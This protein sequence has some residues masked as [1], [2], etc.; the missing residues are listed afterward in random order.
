MPIQRPKPLTFDEQDETAIEHTLRKMM[1]RSEW[2]FWDEKTH[3]E[4]NHVTNAEAF[5]L[6]TVATL[7]YRHL[8][9]TYNKNPDTPPIHLAVAPH[10]NRRYRDA[11]ENARGEEYRRVH[12]RTGVAILGLCFLLPISFLLNVTLFLLLIR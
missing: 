4:L 8:Q 6:A 1:E 5:A 11:V 3:H 9:S 12:Q 2:R 10:I 7:A